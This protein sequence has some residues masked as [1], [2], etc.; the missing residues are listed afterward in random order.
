MSTVPTVLING[1]GGIENKGDYYVF[2]KDSRNNPI[3][4]RASGSV[5]IGDIDSKEIYLVTPLG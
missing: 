1:F 4:K 3:Y 2:I 5:K